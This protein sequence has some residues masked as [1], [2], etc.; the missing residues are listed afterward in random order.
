MNA[1]AEPMARID[2]VRLAA[3]LVDWRAQASILAFCI[4]AQRWTD[5]RNMLTGWGAA[6]P[7][8]V[9]KLAASC[10][11]PVAGLANQLLE[12]GELI[13]VNRSIAIWSDRAASTDATSA[14]D[15]EPTPYRLE[16]L[17]GCAA[18]KALVLALK[19]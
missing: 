12:I 19:R 2:Q 8:G 9:A 10:H 15:V 6:L 13:R 4:E 17:K 1:T 16:V 7:P 3:S 11:E 18:A 14:L 5:V